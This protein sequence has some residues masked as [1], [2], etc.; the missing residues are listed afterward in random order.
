MSGRP[1]PS[2]KRR[3]RKLK[4]FA[5]ALPAGLTMLLL[6]ASDGQS[7]ALTSDMLRQQRDGFSANYRPLQ[8]TYAPA[9]LTGGGSTSSF[10]VPAAS[11]AADTGFD[12]L[13]RKRKI[14]RKRAGYSP[15]VGPPTPGPAPTPITPVIVPIAPTS[16]ALPTAATANRPRL[17]PAMSGG[18]DGQPF[19][20]RL[21][22]DED[23]FGAVGFYRGPFLVKPAIEFLTGYDTNPA[24][25]AGGKG[26]WL[27]MIAPELTAASDWER[28]SLTAD[29]R[30][31]FTGYGMRNEAGA[32]NGVAS[33]LPVNI[34]RPNFI[35]KVNGRFDVSRDTRILSEAR[36]TVGTDNPGSL[37]IQTNLLRYP[38][39][40]STGGT[41]GV[42]QTFN[43][44]EISATGTYDRTVYQNST[45]SDGSTGSNVDRN[46]DQLGGV[47]R[48]SYEI[49]P[50]LRPFGE[51][52]VDKRDRDTEFDRFGYARSSKGDT[53]R[54]GST[55]E[56]GRL[57][58]GEASIGYQNRKYEDT[59]LP[60]ISGWVTTAALAWRPTGLTTVRLAAASSVDESVLP[61]VSGAFVQTYTAEVEH[62]F[63]RYLIATLRTG[64][65]NVTYEGL[66]RDDK[67]Y[68][69]GGD[70]VYKFTRDL[71]AKVQVRHDW[72]NS[73]LSAANYE[74][75][76]FMAGIRLQR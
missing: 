64:L 38:I 73:S 45:F 13:N 57:I 67:V 76:L 43:R 10:G 46:F 63:R 2:R 32:V 52:A 18:V 66:D 23:P 7:Q 28:H 44:F 39:F 51:Y 11:G 65:T 15:T 30:G 33:P 69:I 14:A 61:G 1:G 70:I 21:K 34:D 20:R 71:Q 47:L 75:T 6:G 37:N 29:L 4:G 19:R 54:V 35:G 68:S 58:T 49:S 26:S 53:V 16:P 60:G 5:Q 50:A 3:A 62:A 27:Y 31:T 41:L 42:A 24:R 56:L 55:F 25:F 36:L 48:G 12:S 59:R 17:A 9:T 74:A 40:T 72:L 22:P 8:S